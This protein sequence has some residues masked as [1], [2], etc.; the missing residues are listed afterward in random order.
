ML[1][2]GDQCSLAVRFTRA[3]TVTDNA[4]AERVHQRPGQRPQAFGVRNPGTYR[5][6][7]KDLVIGVTA[8][9]GRGG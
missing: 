7:K 4:S 9:A 3:S 6:R 2:V 8:A 5:V 1:A